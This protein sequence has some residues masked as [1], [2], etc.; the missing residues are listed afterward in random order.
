MKSNAKNGVFAGLIVGALFGILLQITDVST[1][2]GRRITMM[3]LIAES[4]RS[5]SMIIGWA[6]HLFDCAILGAIFGAVLGPRTRTFGEGFRNGPL[7]GLAW[8]ALGG[9][10]LMPFLLAMSVFS[11][12]TV[13]PFPGL[14]MKSLIGH[15]VFG[16]L[17]GPV[18]VALRRRD[19]TADARGIERDEDQRRHLRAG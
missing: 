16:A 6:Y 13:A 10:V 3:A 9:I 12:Q 8:W 11:P 1:P 2:G 4:A 18:F 17:L 14:A 15:V 7:Y 19:K 5:S